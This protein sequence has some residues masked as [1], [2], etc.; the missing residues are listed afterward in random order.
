M[1]G[2]GSNGEKFKVAEPSQTEYAPPQSEQLS[3][4][5][6]RI[7]VLRDQLAEL[8]EAYPHLWPN[9]FKK[10]K[11]AWTTETNAIEGSSLSF[12]DTLFFPRLIRETD[13]ALN[14]QPTNVLVAKTTIP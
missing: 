9:I 6:G 4:S 12:S 5:Y 13:M 3:E 8:K 11:I 2:S 7:D 14:Y 1:N 10:Q